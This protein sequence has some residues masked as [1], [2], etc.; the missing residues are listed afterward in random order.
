[1]IEGATADDDTTT[2][3]VP[4]LS[5]AAAAFMARS[6]LTRT[7]L[8]GLVGRHLVGSV[9]NAT[10]QT[11][12]LPRRVTPGPK[13]VTEDD[14]RNAVDAEA[15]RQRGGTTVNENLVNV[16]LGEL[17]DFGWA[18]TEMTLDPQVRSV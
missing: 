16:L 3:D 9:I 6:H 7:A 18:V 11:T 5:A 13:N 17:A 4:V 10:L 1:L 2:S 15:R 8:H 14:V 12:D